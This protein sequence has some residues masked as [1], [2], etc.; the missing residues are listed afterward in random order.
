MQQRLVPNIIIFYLECYVY[1]S[2][3]SS[4]GTR[5]YFIAFT[6]RFVHSLV[7]CIM[8]FLLLPKGTFNCFRLRK[9]QFVS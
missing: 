1:T 8:D 4:C 5:H 2:P 3:G 6:L 9:I 7:F